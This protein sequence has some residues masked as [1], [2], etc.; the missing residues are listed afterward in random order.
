M[1]AVRRLHDPEHVLNGI[2]AWR[3]GG[4]VEG[5]TAFVVHR[6]ED[7]G[8]VMK[9][10]TVHHLRRAMRQWCL[11]DEASKALLVGVSLDDVVMQDALACDGHDDRELLLAQGLRHG[12]VDASAFHA[13]PKAT[14]VADM[15][16]SFIDA[17]NVRAVQ[18]PLAEVRHGLRWSVVINNFV[19][20]LSCKR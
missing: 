20:L 16:R 19:H 15:E 8:R 2:E 5:N 13:V 11:L 12:D 18:V 3:V 17:H 10:Y 4:N 9:R 1:V 6:L 14:T 7:A